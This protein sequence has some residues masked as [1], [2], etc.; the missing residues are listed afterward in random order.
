[1]KKSVTTKLLLPL[2]VIFGLTITVNLYMT[3]VM[4]RARSVLENVTDANSGATADAMTSA[5]AAEIAQQVIDSINS[6]LATNGLISTTQLAM[7]ILSIGIAYFSIT[8]PLKKITKQLND[9]TEEMEKDEGNLEQRIHTKKVDEIGQ[10]AEG[11]NLYMDKLQKVMQQISGYSAL[12]DD[13]SYHVTEK[14]SASNTDTEMI[15][16]QMGELREDIRGLVTTIEEIISNMNLIAEDIDIMA[17]SAISGAAYSTEMKNRAD[18]IRVLADGSKQ[19]SVN[20]TTQLRGDLLKSVEESKSVDAIQKLTNEIL[21][22]G[23]QTN[24]LALNASIEAARA[25]EAGKG[26]AVVAEE[27][28]IL[29]DNS[30][31]TANSIQEISYEVTEAVRNLAEASEKLLDY[32]STTVSKDYDEFVKSAK[33]YLEDANKMEG[34]MNSFNQEATIFVEATQNMSSKLS[35]VSEEVE[36]ENRHVERLSSAVEKLGS[37]MKDISHYTGIN[38][39]ISSDLKEEISKFKKI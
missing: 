17:Q 30:K 2:L 28:R 16:Y 5:E 38:K 8:R 3:A 33:D 12:L 13:S 37:N 29:A 34:L 6:S 27:I 24:L 21:S 9:M 26:F 32:V 11:I 20:I 22:I 1:M 18:H 14:V 23:N 35:I 36:N 39:G 7:V 10:V 15:S 4:Q 31:E 19:E 25:G